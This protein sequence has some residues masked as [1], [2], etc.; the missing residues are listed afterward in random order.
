MPRATAARR[1]LLW[2]V[3]G[4]PALAAL[5]AT[6]DLDQGTYGAIIRA[7]AQ[8]LAVTVR[9]TAAA[10]LAAL[11][12]GT[13]VALALVSHR[14]WLARAARAYVE[15]MRGVPMLV[16][17]YYI[18]FAVGPAVVSLY[19]HLCAR[20][21]EAGLLPEVT[22]RD[23]GFEWRA[24]LALTIGCSAFIAEVIRGGIAAVPSEQSEAAHALGL[25]RR[26]TMRLVVLPQA[27]KAMLPPLGNDLVSMLK[28]SSLVSVLG[29][30]DITQIGKTYSAA[31]FL[32]FET[33]TVVAVFY[34]TMTIGLSLVVRRLEYRLRT[35][36]RTRARGLA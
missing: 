28:D 21:I 2:W 9:V 11:V 26:Q 1:R 17:L 34:L 20:L 31:T 23:F 30:G 3:I 4:L 35:T 22:I 14:P 33:Y 19:A 15:V 29:V 32:F 16:L 25:G 8:G 5:G 36:E 13:L 18:A 27:F 24:I 12:A 6:L 7:V 10:F